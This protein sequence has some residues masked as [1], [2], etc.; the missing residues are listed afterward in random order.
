MI[1]EVLDCNGYLIVGVLDYRHFVVFNMVFSTDLYLIVE[2]LDYSVLTDRR[3]D[4]HGLI[5]SASDPDLRG[6]KRF[7]MPVAYFPTNLVYPFTRE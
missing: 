1:V 4:G 7:L 3:T 6:R 5:D 2:V